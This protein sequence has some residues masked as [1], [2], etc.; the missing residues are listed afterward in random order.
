[1]ENLKIFKVNKVLRMAIQVIGYISV[2]FL[3]LY[4]YIYIGK[5]IK[6]EEPKINF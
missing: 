2:L 4:H 3:E 6:K 5:K 1:M